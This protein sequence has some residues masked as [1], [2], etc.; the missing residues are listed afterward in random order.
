M[1]CP[2]T[3]IVYHPT[4]LVCGFCTATTVINIFA[5]TFFKSKYFQA[6]LSPVFSNCFLSEYLIPLLQ[7][8]H[9]SFA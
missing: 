5:T 3:G 4:I 2:Y 8:E 9:T 6:F 1:P 7:A